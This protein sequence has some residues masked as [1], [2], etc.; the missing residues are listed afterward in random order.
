[1]VSCKPIWNCCCIIRN[2]GIYPK[3]RSQW[4]SKA[5][6]CVIIWGADKLHILKLQLEKYPILFKLNNLC[7]LLRK[8]PRIWFGGFFVVVVWFLFVFFA[9]FCRIITVLEDLILCSGNANSYVIATV[10]TV[11]G[12]K[13]S[14]SQNCCSS[15]CICIW[16]KCNFAQEMCNLPSWCISYPST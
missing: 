5:G 7:Y 8:M 16:P 6:R 13:H 3:C 9:F 12:R 1:M 14:E 10:Y 2:I 15:L 11:G 4:K